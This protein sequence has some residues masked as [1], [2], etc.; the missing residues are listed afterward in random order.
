M[1]ESAQLFATAQNY[2]PGGVNS[3]V[4]AFKGVGGDPIFFE[5]AQGAYIYD[6]AGNAYIDYVGSWGPMILGHGH[7][8]VLQAVHAAVDKALTFG[9]PTE[10]EVTMAAKVCSIMPSMEQVRF[11]SSGTEAAMTAIRLARAATGRDKII[12][13]DGCY[14]G[15]A[16]SLLVQ[17]GS[18]A[19]TLGVPSSPGVPKDLAQHTLV[20]RFNDLNSVEQ[21]FAAHPGK[22]AAV[23]IEPIAGNMNLIPPLPNF[24][25]DLKKLCH[26]HGA[27]VIFDEVISGFRAALNGAQ[28]IYNVSPDLT[29]LGKIIGGG[30]P[31]GA[32]GGKRDIMQLLAPVGPVYQAGTLSGN[33]VAMAAGLATLEVISAPGFFDKISQ[34]AKILAD[35]L[36]EIAVALNIPVLTR[37]SGGL[38]GLFFTEQEQINNLDDVKLCNADRFKRF[39]HAMLKQGV[40]LPPSAYETCFVSIMHDEKEIA[41]TLAAAEKAFAEAK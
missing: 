11:V 7:P 4:R 10:L 25:A 1:A 32:F 31:V 29:V 41:K 20:A 19:L 17:A 18:G 37:A 12:K 8:K 40:Y 9:A 35:G 24:L 16:D 34:T 30:F 14:H 5:R 2:I 21:L 13:F 27:L 33:P 23:I 28:G 3:P 15:H 38:F 39:F 6:V 26:Q 36:S 22:I